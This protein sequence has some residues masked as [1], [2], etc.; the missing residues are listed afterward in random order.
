M[1]FGSHSFP[2]DDCQ[3]VNR[4]DL[5]YLGLWCEKVISLGAGRTRTI[6]LT[7]YMTIQHAE[8]CDLNKSTIQSL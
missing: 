7:L 8:V 1:L 6:V 2:L 4:F 5:S 3:E